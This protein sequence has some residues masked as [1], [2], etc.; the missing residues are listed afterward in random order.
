MKKF[1]VADSWG[2][3]MSRKNFVEDGLEYL[4]FMDTV[5]IF[6]GVDLKDFEKGL[7]VITPSTIQEQFKLREKIFYIVGSEAFPIEMV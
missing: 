3:Q 5:A 6:D 7:D 1:P 4:S 2:K